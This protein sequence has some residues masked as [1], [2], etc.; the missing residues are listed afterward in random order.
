MRTRFKTNAADSLVLAWLFAA[1]LAVQAQT[2]AVD[3]HKVA[4]GG[5]SSSNGTLAITGTIG[6]HDAPVSTEANLMIAGGFLGGATNQSPQAAT[7]VYSRAPN[8]AL[9]IK[10]TD[11]LSNSSDPRG[12]ALGL[13]DVQP[14]TTNN[15]ALTANGTTVFY[16]GPNVDDAFTYTIVNSEGAA[17]TGLILIHVTSATSGSTVA[18][19]QIGVPGEGTNTVSFAGIPNYQYLVQFA[20]NLTDS[21]W[22]NLST[23]TAGANGLWT[24]VDP[25][26]TNAQRF[27]RVSTP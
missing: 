21:P 2:P 16:A 26:A 22:F 14:A 11:L 5:A 27:Y 18:R 7:L 3:W 9:R 17:S 20:T 19:L 15:V 10:V 1:C 12:L 13:R 8:T 23:N 24:V 4:G 25:S 6:Q